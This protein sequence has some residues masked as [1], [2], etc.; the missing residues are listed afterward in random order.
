MPPTFVDLVGL[1]SQYQDGVYEDMVPFTAFRVQLAGR[2]V[3][4]SRHRPPHHVVSLTDLAAIDPVVRSWLARH[5]LGRLPKLFMT[6]GYM[7]AALLQYGA[8]FG[9]VDLVRIIASSNP[10]F[11]HGT[12]LPLLALAIASGSTPTVEVVVS[13]GYLTTHNQSLAVQ[14][15]A[16]LGHV[17]ILAVLVTAMPPPSFK[18]ALVAAAKRNHVPVVEYLLPWCTHEHRSLALDAAVVAGAADTA[19]ALRAAGGQ[20]SCKALETSLTKGRLHVLG[21]LLESTSSHEERHCSLARTILSWAVTHNRLSLVRWILNVAPTCR[22]I[23]AT[24]LTQV[25][26]TS[27]V[28]M[29]QVLCR[30]KSHWDASV[31]RAGLKL[32]IDCFLLA[33]ANGQLESLASMYPLTCNVPRVF[34]RAARRAAASRHQ[35]VVRWL[36]ASGKVPPEWRTRLPSFVMPWC[37]SKTITLHP[38]TRMNVYGKAATHVLTSLERVICIRLV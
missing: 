21:R 29:V 3:L 20:L 33:S 35:H 25:A 27:P 2:K 12:P 16:T 37:H 24:H 7:E 1:I 22:P 14:S 26:S 8:C 4:A 11:H 10:L 36:V 5:G 6:I 19:H 31:E 9:R 15:A 30:R 17:A 18:F 32:Y 38:A 28:D 13:L 23:L 34:M